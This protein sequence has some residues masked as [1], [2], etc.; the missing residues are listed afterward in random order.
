MCPA[1][2][3][4]LVTYELEGIEIDRCLKC[5]GAWLDAGEL[6]QIGLLEGVP[7][8]RLTEALDRA[9]GDS[10]GGRTCLRCGGGL[11]RVTVQGVDLDRCPW[12][13]GLWFDKGE[14]RTLVVSLK[15]GEEGVVARFFGD[16]FRADIQK[17]G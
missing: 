15:E 14:M 5:K 4:P 7:P 10:H 16:L 17:G 9:G 2:R 3:E 8:G 1:C 11:K 13:H 12:G 6:D